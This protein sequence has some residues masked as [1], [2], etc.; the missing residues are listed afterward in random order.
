ME[1]EMRICAKLKKNFVFFTLLS[2]LSDF[3]SLIKFYWNLPINRMIS[4]DCLVVGQFLQSKTVNSLSTD[5]L[6]QRIAKFFLKDAA[7]FP[8]FDFKRAPWEWKEFLQNIPIG[9]NRRRRSKWWK[10]FLEAILVI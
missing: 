5:Y 1:K 8:H 10:R 3:L 4:W 7:I 2:E 9:K 6:T